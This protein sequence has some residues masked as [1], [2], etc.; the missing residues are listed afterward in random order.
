MK[1]NNLSFRYATRDD[2]ELILYFI[3][4]IAKY[5]KMEDEVIATKESLEY[6][7]FDK[8]QAEVIFAMLDNKEIGFALFF[9]N[10]S[11]FQGKAGLYLED[12]FI[13]ESYRG[14]G[15]GKAIFKEL[16]TIA[17]K[18]GCGRMEWCCLDWNIPSI[19]FYKSMGAIPMDTWTTYR[20]DREKI[21][22][23][24]NKE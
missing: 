9:H 6:W 2:V 13:L 24:A 3:K 16:A 11:T 12:I 4:A 20:L 10:F 17:L 21:E 22:E 18:R 19:N 7:L 1:K 23:L 14:K 15:Y 5:E 8:T